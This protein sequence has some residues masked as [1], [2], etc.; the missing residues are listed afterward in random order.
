MKTNANKSELKANLAKLSKDNEVLLEGLDTYVNENLSLA[1][2]NPEAFNKG[3]M[4]YKSKLDKNHE[5]IHKL[6]LEI[7]NGMINE[8]RLKIIQDYIDNRSTIGEGILIK[9]FI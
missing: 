5:T 7:S 9:N 1:K 6:N 2:E 3:Y 8:S 4:K